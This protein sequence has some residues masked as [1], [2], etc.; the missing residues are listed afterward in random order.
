MASLSGCI[1]WGCKMDLLRDFAFTLL[2]HL[3]SPPRSTT[4]WGARNPALIFFFSMAAAQ[5]QRG[6]PDRVN[7]VSSSI[8]HSSDF[9][10]E[11]PRVGWGQCY[12]QE[13]VS[14]SVSPASLLTPGTLKYLGA[15]YF[16]S[17]WW[18]DSSM[19]KLWSLMLPKLM[20]GFHPFPLKV[21]GNSLILKLVVQYFSKRNPSIFFLHIFLLIPMVYPQRASKHRKDT[22][23]LPSGIRNRIGKVKVRKLVDWDKER[24]M[25]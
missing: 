20:S 10:S 3:S 9:Q 2:L 12:R 16:V 8:S 1:L 17:S 14:W 19:E 11:I 23:F 4:L 21:R 18:R 6:G 24:L 5:K 7:S 15:S 25:I 13:L 22:H